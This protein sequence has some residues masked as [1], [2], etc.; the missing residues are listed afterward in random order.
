M[1]TRMLRMCGSSFEKLQRAMCH[2]RLRAALRARYCHARDGCPP[3]APQNSACAS[4]LAKVQ[5]GHLSL[6]LMTICQRFVPKPPHASLASTGNPAESMTGTRNSLW[7]TNES[8]PGL[9]LVRIS[10]R[11]PSVGRRACAPYHRRAYS[12]IGTSVRGTGRCVRGLRPRRPWDTV[13][14]ASSPVRGI[15]FQVHMSELSTVHRK[16]SVS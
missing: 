16:V 6:R 4:P 11:R 12:G 10:F 1:S 3:N 9:S 7:Q 13:E 2:V 5:A 8:D 15:M 14:A